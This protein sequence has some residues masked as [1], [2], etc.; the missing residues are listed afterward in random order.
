MFTSDKVLEPVVTNALVVNLPMIKKSEDPKSDLRMKL[1]VG[2]VENT[3]LIRVAME[4]PNGEEAITIVQAV[5]D[6]YISAK[7]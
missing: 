6:S 2:I 4:L 1:R 7:Y 5:I 3:N